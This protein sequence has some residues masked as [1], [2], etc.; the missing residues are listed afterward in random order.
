VDVAL[1][2]LTLH[3]FRN[4]D[5]LRLLREAA[6]VARVRVVVSDLERTR[7]AWLGARLLS[8]TLWRTNPITRHDGP[9]SVRRAFR[10]GELEE[11]GRRAGLRDVRVR[12]HLPWRLSLVG[13][14]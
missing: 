10:T 12:R 3:H 7:A 5:A 11:L 13:R 4:E 1:C 8:A 14:P 6:R 9:L 2:T